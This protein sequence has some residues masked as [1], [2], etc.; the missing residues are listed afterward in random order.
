VLL[1][2]AL[3]GELTLVR[4]ETRPNIDHEGAPL[5]D[6]FSTTTSTDGAPPSVNNVSG[7]YN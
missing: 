6:V 1:A 7:K 2:D 5:G 4:V 3:A